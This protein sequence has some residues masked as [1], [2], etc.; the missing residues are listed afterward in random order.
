MSL[1]Y[2]ILQLS[3]LSV[4]ATSLFG[5]PQKKEFNDIK[6]ID[7]LVMP[8]NLPKNPYTPSSEKT[9]TEPSDE[10]IVNSTAFIKKEVS[11]PASPVPAEKIQKEPVPKRDPNHKMDKAEL[12]QFMQTDEYKNWRDTLGER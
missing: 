2:Q 1:K 12:E 10:K 6:G 3:A 7:S 9:L 11:Q 4:A 5:M 8:V